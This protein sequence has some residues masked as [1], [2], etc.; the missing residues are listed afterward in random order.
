R[1]DTG[2]Y[3]LARWTTNSPMTVDS[4]KHLDARCITLLTRRSESNIG[5]A[6]HIGDNQRGD[7]TWGRWK[8]ALSPRG[9]LLEQ[10][11]AVSI[12]KCFRSWIVWQPNAR[13][14]TNPE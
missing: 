11:C 8:L 4:T 14:M 10:G 9:H 3:S 5:C 6:F 2:F 1:K 13:P 12:L 7:C